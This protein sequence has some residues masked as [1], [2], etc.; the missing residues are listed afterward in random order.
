LPLALAFSHS[1]SL[2]FLAADFSW[3]REESFGLFFWLIAAGFAMHKYERG[4]TRFCH[5]DFSGL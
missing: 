4:L 3:Q 1:L 2:N 5:T